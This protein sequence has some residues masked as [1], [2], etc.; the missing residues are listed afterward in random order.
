MLLNKLASASHQTGAAEKATSLD[1]TPPEKTESSTP[2]APHELS[3]LTSALRSRPSLQTSAAKRPASKDSDDTLDRPA[4]RMSPT[5]ENPDS[6]LTATSVNSTTEGSSKPK[7]SPVASK[8]SSVSTDQAK[9]NRRNGVTSHDRVIAKRLDPETKTASGLVVPDTAAKKP[10][11]GEILA[12][13][14]GGRDEKAIQNA[15]GAKVDGNELLIMR[16]ED[17]MATIS[18]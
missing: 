8:S 6:A 14:P 5:G 3:G 18:K 10:A 13:G 7:P 17:I 1:R 16:E 4:K 2:Q 9:E 15:S 11:Q 12:G